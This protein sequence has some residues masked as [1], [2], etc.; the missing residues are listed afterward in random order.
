MFLSGHVAFSSR[1]PSGH[2][3]LQT[4]CGQLLC[5]LRAFTPSHLRVFF[6][7]QTKRPDSDCIVNINSKLGQR[8]RSPGVKKKQK[9]KQNCRLRVIERENISC[10]MLWGLPDPL[11]HPCSSF[12]LSLYPL[13]LLLSHFRFLSH[14]AVI[15][16]A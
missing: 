12:P 2:D 5:N 8:V 13:S 4:T 9:T 1:L 14:M 11:N 16:L 10:Q 3:A 6:I 7:I 15:T